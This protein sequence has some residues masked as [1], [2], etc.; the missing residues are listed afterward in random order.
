LLA[1][2]RLALCRPAMR[3]RCVRVGTHPKNA[4]FRPCRAG[5]I[6]GG[7]KQRYG[8]AWQESPQNRCFLPVGRATGIATGNKPGVSGAAQDAPRRGAC[9][10]G[11]R[12]NLA[13]AADPGRRREAFWRGGLPPVKPARKESG[14]VPPPEIGTWGDRGAGGAD[15][16]KRGGI[17][18]LSPAAASQ[19]RTRLRSVT[20]R[21]GARSRVCVMIPAH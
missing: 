9:G 7:P 16:G 18:Q 21:R 6:G 4:R 19:V 3:W 14:R 10:P 12:Q 20:R 2:C 8:D 17:P 1:L 13:W 11:G 15:Q 5:H